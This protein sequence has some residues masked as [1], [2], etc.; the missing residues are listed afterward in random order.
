MN[1]QYF[2]YLL[3]ISVSFIATIMLLGCN[4]P[5]AT[6]ESLRPVK[7]G[8]VTSKDV[9]RERVFSGIAR[10]AG[11]TELSFKVSGTV[12]KINMKVGETFSAGKLLASLDRSSFI[13]QLDQAKADAAKAEALRRSAE[14]EYQRIRQLYANDNASRNEL[15]SALAES[16]SASANYEAMVQAAK[17]AALN[18]DYTHLM[19]QRNCTVANIEIEEN[20]NVTANQRIATASCGNDW[21]VLINVPESVIGQFSDGLEGQIQFPSVPKET[22][23]GSV[24]EIGI[25]MSNRSTFPITLALTDFPDSI[26]NNLAAEASFQFSSDSASRVIYVPS[27]AVSQDQSGTFVFVVL[28]SDS[29]AIWQLQKR[30][31]EIGELNTNGLEVL[32]G[33]NDGERILLAGHVNARDGLLVRAD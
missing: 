23:K 30:K 8:V 11:E 13:V 9:S 27:T 26:R 17:L 4:E 31:V 22:Y 20:E 33:L 12:N 10:S 14:S 18:V 21:E 6:K 32:K 15:D 19:L 25:G 3:S 1:I 24:V 28:P 16:E 29:D 7:S 5:V 2:H